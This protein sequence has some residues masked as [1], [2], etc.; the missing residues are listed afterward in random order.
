MKCTAAAA[1][2]E[3]E[4]ERSNC[5]R[6]QPHTKRKESRKKNPNHTE[7]HMCGVWHSIHYRMRQNNVLLWR[8]RRNEMNTKKI[9]IYYATHCVSTHCLS[10]WRR[11]LSTTEPKW[12]RKKG[13]KNKLNFFIS[14]VAFLPSPIWDDVCSAF[15]KVWFFCCFLHFGA[16]LTR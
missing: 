14:C 7:A 11:W 8:I 2:W 13:V 12:C 5:P 15:M 9:Y 1:E 3:R 6:L 10:R 16:T 4:R